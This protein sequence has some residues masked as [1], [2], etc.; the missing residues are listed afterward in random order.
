MSM[1]AYN[2]VPQ[3]ELPSSRTLLRSTLIAAGVASVILITIVMPAEYGVDPTGVGN[4]LGLTEMGRIKV[5]LEEEAA[6]AAVA[7]TTAQAT[8]ATAPIAATTG[9][10]AAGRADT[11]SIALQPGQGREIKLV[12]RNGARVRY[13]W[14][15]Q[16]G[17]VNYD[18]HGDSVGAARDFYH[19][20]GKGQNSTGEDGVLTAAFKGS[21]GWFWRNRGREP[22]TVIL[23]TTGEYT[24]LKEIK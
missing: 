22:V 10:P 4:V 23:R 13:A 21:H 17:A 2:D 6:A 16:G 9:A 18:T 3:N 15:T 20:Y 7:D 14:T 8:P 1:P 24:E 12:M 11:T 19:G 5:S